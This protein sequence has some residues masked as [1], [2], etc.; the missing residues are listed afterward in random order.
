MSYSNSSTIYT[1]GTA[2]SRAE[3][4]GVRVEVLVGGQWL[5]GFIVANDGVGLV[6]NSDGEE[7]S[8]VRIEGISAV[9]V[10]TPAPMSQPLPAASQARP[11]PRPRSA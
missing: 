9:R 4:L 7:H 3:Q 6:L 11:M 5:A 2:L 10:L 8:V 1:M